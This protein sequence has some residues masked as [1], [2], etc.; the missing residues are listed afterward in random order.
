M[1]CEI[2]ANAMYFTGNIDNESAHQFVY[3]LR[4]LETRYSDKQNK[5]I[6]LYLCSDGGR[7]TSALRMYDILNQSSLNV[8]VVCEGYVASSGTI[9][10]LGAKRRLCTAHTNFLIHPIS[11]GNDGTLAYLKSNIKFLDTLDDIVCSIYNKHTFITRTMID[12]ETFLTAEQ[13]KQYAL[14]D[15]VI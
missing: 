9:V 3:Y 1:V 12:V 11:S 8:T 2:A 15:E 13:A 6:T 4:E 10:M 7:V 5:N 14:I